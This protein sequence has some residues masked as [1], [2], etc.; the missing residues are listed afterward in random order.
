MTDG[1]AV[2]LQQPLGGAESHMDAL[3][4][5][6]LNIGEHEQLFDTGMIA[7]LAFK[8]GMSVAPLLG[9][10]SLGDL[11]GDELIFD[12]IS[13]DAVVDFRKRAVEVPAER[14]ALVL[15]VFEALEVFDRIE[16][17]LD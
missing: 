10:L 9:S 2:E 11:G 3:C 1:I 5:H 16:L 14:E 13:V 7:E 12:R 6:G 4:V 17:K 15:V 8:V